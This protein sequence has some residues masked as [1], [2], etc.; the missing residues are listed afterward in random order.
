[1]LFFFLCHIRENFSYMIQV[2]IFVLWRLI[3]LLWCLSSSG[4]TVYVQIFIIQQDKG[5]SWFLCCCYRHSFCDS[6]LNK[7]FCIECLFGISFWIYFQ[8]YFGTLPKNYSTYPNQIEVF[9]WLFSTI[10][11][12]AIFR[13]FFRSQSITLL[14]WGF[15]QWESPRKSFIMS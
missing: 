6:M 9:I 5:Y 10:P 14:L 12:F 1:M 13:S 15:I 11:Y 2:F 4:C 8:G 7:H 3:A